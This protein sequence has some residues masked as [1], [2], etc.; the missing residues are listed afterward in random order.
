MMGAG[1]VPPPAPT[2][3]SQLSFKSDPNQRMQ[4]KNFMQGL[5]ANQQAPV[6]PAMMPMPQIPVPMQNIDV[7]AQ[8]VQFMQRGGI[9][10]RPVAEMDYT[11]ANVA[12]QQE[13][14][15]KSRI[16]KALERRE[17][18][19]QMDDSNERRNFPKLTPTP[20]KIRDRGGILNVDTRTAAEI[21]AEN[22]IR[23]ARE[24]KQQGE[25]PDD[26]Y[27]SGSGAQTE[28]ELIGLPSTDSP[29]SVRRT[30]SYD[31]DYITPLESD[32]LNQ[33]ESLG[34]LDFIGGLLSDSAPFLPTPSSLDPVDR[35]RMDPDLTR[36]GIAATFL[37]P[38]QSGLGT[39]LSEQISRLQGMDANIDDTNQNR[40]FPTETRTEIQQLDDEDKD[41]TTV[42]KAIEPNFLSRLPGAVGDFFY[43]GQ[44]DN[45][46]KLASL[47]NFSYD[48]ETGVGTVPVGSRGGELVLSPSGV[49]TYR[50]QKDPNY[51][52]DDP[53]ATLIRPFERSSKSPSDPCPPGYVMIN[54]ACTPITQPATTATAPTTPTPNVIQTT[55]V[56]TTPSPVVPSTAP[57]VQLGMPLGQTTPV[58]PMSQFFTNVPN[59]LNTAASNFLSALSS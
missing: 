37:D 8:P 56:V 11:P 33:G 16:Q 19:R 6:V 26:L 36:A 30:A 31:P 34:M 15:E 25:F 21:N 17:K 22:A 7:F 45:F 44:I 40:S 20:P 39:S 49:I 51:S 47:P 48:N 41:A 55:P 18:A 43:K 53:F 32:A 28:A 42:L 52:V 46:K 13:E 35:R 5:S 24:L 58:Q 12:K 1:M 4:F 10:N 2:P 14:V 23:R 9:T 50:G 57:P 38:R 3:P 27:G 29:L 59:S 54:G